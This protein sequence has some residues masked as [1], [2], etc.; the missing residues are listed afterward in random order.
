MKI[1]KQD[2]NGDYVLG[3][4]VDFYQNEPAAVAQAVQ[5]R[6]LLYTGEWFIDTSDGMPWRT[7][8]L[9]KYTKQA[10]DTVMKQR[11]LGT[12]GVRA[13]LDYVSSFDGNTRILSYSFT[14]DTIYGQTPVQGTI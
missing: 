6:L 2:A 14:L 12:P 3:T 7:D 9:G 8:V 4:T 5:T 1:R 10:Y 13:I 11:V